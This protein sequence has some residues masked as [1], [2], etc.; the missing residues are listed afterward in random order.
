MLNLRKFIRKFST[1]KLN[2]NFDN[3]LSEEE[4]LV[5]E[6][7]KQYAKNSL[8]PR[9]LDSFRNETF[10]K[11]IMKEMGSIGLLGPTINGYGCSGTNYISYG[12]I[13]REIERVDS[14]YRSAMSV[15]SSLVMHPIYK[16]GTKEQKE[17]YLP[18]LAKGDLIGCFGLTEPNHGSDPSSMMTRATKSDNNYILNG[19]KNWITNSPIA[20]IFIVWAKD[21]NNDIR[22]FILERGMKGISTPKIN[23]K[24]SLRGSITGMIFMDN[25]IVPKENML[26]VKG[27]K[28]P[29]TCLNSARYGISWGVLG[30]AEDCFNRVL[31]YTMGRKQFSVPLAS[32]QLIQIKMA[33]MITEITL[34]LHAVHRVGRLIDSNDYVPEMISLVKRNNCGKALKIARDSRDILGGNGISDEYHIM[35]HMVNLEAVNTYEGTHDIHGLIL[36]KSLTGYPAF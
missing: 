3:L 19:S 6:T 11:K 5:Q 33:D 22:G 17:K 21:D 30:T 18:E 29:F 7:A 26:I 27:L 28:G 9:I 36:G 2:F 20:D 25:V 12:L 34:G 15:Q 35:R 32:K 16:F 13:A 4:K 8:Q 23:G 14:G 1:N 24:L 31:E 10:D